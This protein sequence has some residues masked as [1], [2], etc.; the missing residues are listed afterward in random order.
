MRNKAGN[1]KCFKISRKELMKL[2]KINS[3]ST[4]HRCISDLVKLKYIS[5]A[6]SFN[7]HEG[8]KI[9]ILIEQSY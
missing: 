3:S 2:S 9:E 7:Y 5:Y 1:Q 8:S 6:P 4:Y